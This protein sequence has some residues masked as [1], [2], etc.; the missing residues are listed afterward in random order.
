[1][2][3]QAKVD[4]EEPTGFFQDGTSA[5]PVVD[6]TVARGQL[7]VDDA[8]FRGMANGKPVDKFPMAVTKDMLVRGQERYTIFCAACHGALGDG[9]GMIVQ[10]GMIHPPSYHTERLRTAPVGHFYDV[11]DNGFGA[12]YPYNDRIAPADR[13]AIIAYIRALQLSQNAMVSQ[14]PAA[15]QRSLTEGV[16]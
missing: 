10:R 7:R 14:L 3:Q 1:M 15:D 11:I 13:W 8:M 12:M 2:A 5:R 16:K 6:G 9:E 4:P